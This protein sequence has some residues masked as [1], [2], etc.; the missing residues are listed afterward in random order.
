MS[1]DGHGNDRHRIS[2]AFGKDSYG[3]H[4]ACG[5]FIYLAR[6]GLGNGLQALF[7]LAMGLEIGHSIDAIDSDMF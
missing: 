5:Q 7:D 1:D 3:L 2:N 6:G 4:G